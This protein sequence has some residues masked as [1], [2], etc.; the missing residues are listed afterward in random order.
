M[1]E[2]NLKMGDK[3]QE[4]KRLQGKL[5]VNADGDFGSKTQAATK[6]KQ[7]DMGSQQTG[8]ADSGFLKSLGME[9]IPGIDVSSHNGVIDWNAV[10]KSGVKFA[11]IKHTEGATHKN[12][13]HA[14][15]I[16]MA[17]DVGL[18]AGAYHFG[19]SDTDRSPKLGDA[20]KEAKWFLSLYKKHSCD[21]V[22][23]L[24]VENGIKTDDNY[25][26]EW[27]LKWLEVVG[28]ELGCRPC[29]YT[30]TWAED[31]YLARADGSLLSQLGQYPLW[32][33]SYTDKSDVK[34]MPKT[35]DEWDV[36]QWTG[37]GSVPGIKGRCDQNWMTNESLNKL[38]MK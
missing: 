31:L 5:G 23:V 2:F 1:F 8:I 15:N 38:I 27:S 11:W 9:V 13:R 16:K 17:R 35:W 22:P 6:L 7:K 24:D 21:L 29:V 30:A 18:R 26:V 34:R 37:S 10:A 20:V 32:L 25:N 4:V 36:W 33:A 3:G 28:K 12:P 14:E 19:R